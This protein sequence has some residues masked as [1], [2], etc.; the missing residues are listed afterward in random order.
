MRF[1][2]ARVSKDRQ[3]DVRV[4]LALGAEVPRVFELLAFPGEVVARIPE[5][6]RYRYVVA[7]N[8]VVIVDPTDRGVVLVIDE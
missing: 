7:E 8:D 5:V 4:R 3:A 2:H 6:E 1:I